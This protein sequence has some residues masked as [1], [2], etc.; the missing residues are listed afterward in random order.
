MICIDDIW[1][2]FSVVQEK[3]TFILGS[4]TALDVMLYL[5]WCHSLYHISSFL[6]FEITRH[7]HPRYTNKNS[8]H[9]Y[10]DSCFSYVFNYRLYCKSFIL[11]VT[12]SFQ[13]KTRKRER[14]K[15]RERG[16]E[17]ERGKKPK[18]YASVLLTSRFLFIPTEQDQR[19]EFYGYRQTYCSHPKQL[20]TVSYYRLSTSL[21]LWEILY[22]H[23]PSSCVYVQKSHPPKR[24]YSSTISDQSITGVFIL[25]QPCSNN[26]NKKSRYR[27]SHPSTVM[28]IS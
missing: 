27:L 10:G 2:G 20:R 6:L 11:F 7:D 9:V 23:D 17:G 14:E 5:S 26:N 8:K 22:T 1:I 19:L 12:I 18:L 25:A 24:L 21:F 16:R 13:V 3:D 4:H 15:E 28:I